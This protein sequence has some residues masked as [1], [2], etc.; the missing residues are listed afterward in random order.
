VRFLPEVL[1][2]KGTLYPEL[3][4]RGIYEAVLYNTRLTISGRFAVPQCPE[5][6]TIPPEDI[7]WSQAT[8]GLSVNDMRGI[9]D[10]VSLAWDD[11]AL[12]LEP[13]SG[14]SANGYS[15]IGARPPG[16]AFRESVAFRV[17]L[18]LNGSG[19]LNCVPLGKV[20]TLELSSAWP[21]PS[22]SGAFL[23][24]S[25]A[26]SDSGFSA[27][28]KVLHL[29]RAFPQVWVNQEHDTWSAAFGVDLLQ[30]VDGYHKVERTAKYAV[31][32]I[33]L[34]FLSFFLMEVMLRRRVHPVQYLLVGFALCLFYVLLLSLS[35]HTGFLA[36]YV[37][38]G[39]AVVVLVSGYS[40]AVLRS[41]RLA[42]LQ[43]G[44]LALLYAFLY[45]VLQLEDYALLIGSIGLFVILGAVMYLTRNIDWYSTGSTAG[46][47][48]PGNG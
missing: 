23:P 19:S 32:F 29:N 4:Y 28:W 41:A 12:L 36:A 30:P 39:A 21:T 40:R 2:I 33:G 34:T 16:G 47:P 14:V 45:V 8:V 11:T 13:M 15:G 22:F 35:E 26:V 24:E 5:W 3:R 38:A 43:G 42:V 20:T 17:E 9:R 44:L 37:V 7:L 18:D 25:R 27:K 31:L 1:D 46:V 48:H 6:S 10:S